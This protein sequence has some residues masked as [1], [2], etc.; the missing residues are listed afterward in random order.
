MPVVEYSENQN[1][2][3]QAAH[4]LY[5]GLKHW[6]LWTLLAWNDLYQRYKRT[7]IGMG[8]IALSFALFALVKIFIFGP[9]TGKSLSFYGPYLAVGF[10]SFRLISNFISNGANVYVGAQSWIKSE[11]LPLSVHLYK[12]LTSNFIIFGFMTVPS[13]LICLFFGV[14]DPL[15]LA[16]LPF[17]LITYALNGV[18]LSSLIGI[19]CARHRDLMHFVTTIM[20]VLYFATPILWVAPETGIRATLAN[21]NPLTHFIAILREPVLKSTIPWDSWKLMGIYTI[22]GL[23]ISFLVFAQS[24]KRLIYWL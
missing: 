7:W 20:Q 10:L 11:P 19:M 6:R 17:A 1:I 3:A 5:A 18:W 16:V 23:T 12:L 4:D 21:I 8:W 24:R 2:Y 13:V 15:V 14:S 22:V 9:M